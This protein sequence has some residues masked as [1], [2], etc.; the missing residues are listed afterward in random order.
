MGRGRGRQGR[1]GVFKV[2]VEWCREGKVGEGVGWG[3]V[4]EGIG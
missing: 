4:G 2:G 3:K 1:V